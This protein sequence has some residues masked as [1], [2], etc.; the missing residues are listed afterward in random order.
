VIQEDRHN[1]FWHHSQPKDEIDRTRMQQTDLTNNFL[2][3]ITSNNS[4]LTNKKQKIPLS[5]T[6]RDESDDESSNSQASSNSQKDSPLVSRSSS[7]T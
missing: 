7:T 3:L 4:N 1:G 6:T 2:S 5:I